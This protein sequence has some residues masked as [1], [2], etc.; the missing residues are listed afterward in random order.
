MVMRVLREEKALELIK[1]Q[2]VLRSCKEPSD[3]VSIR[4]VKEKKTGQ[5]V[6][7][8]TSVGSDC[9]PKGMR[10]PSRMAGLRLISVTEIVWRVREAA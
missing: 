3:D 7:A 9:C 2:L 8:K 4:D 6:P 5:W 1:S 10:Q